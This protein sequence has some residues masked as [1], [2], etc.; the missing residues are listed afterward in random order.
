MATKEHHNEEHHWTIKAAAARWQCHELTVRRKI[1]RG[2][3]KVLRFS[4]QCVR[5]PYAEIL[6]CELEARA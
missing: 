6:R 1:R 2:E 5:I 3:L 4:P